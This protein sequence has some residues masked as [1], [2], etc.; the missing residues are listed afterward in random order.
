MAGMN[1]MREALSNPDIPPEI[2][3]FLQDILGNYMSG[4]VLAPFFLIVSILMMGIISVIFA[5][6]GSI[7]GVALFQKKQPH[8]NQ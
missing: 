4:E 5:T 8:V 7:I 1:A 2:R 3:E 6:I